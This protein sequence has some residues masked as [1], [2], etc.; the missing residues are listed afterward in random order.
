MRRTVDFLLY[1]WLVIESLC[2]R[3]RFSEHSR[4]TLASVIDACEQIA[5]EQFAPFNRIVDTEEPQVRNGRVILPRCAYTAAR[6]YVNSGM[7]AAAQDRELGG[8]QLPFVVQTAANSFF[9]KAVIGLGG[10]YG[11]TVANAN[12]L[13]AHATERQKRIFARNQFAGRWFGTMCL[14]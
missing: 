1:D 3:D 7:L 6:A 14:S 11:L 12:L 13:M 9:A 5:K 10:G 4:H 2:G 8:V